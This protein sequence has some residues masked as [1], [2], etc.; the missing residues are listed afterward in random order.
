MYINRESLGG[1]LAERLPIPSLQNVTAVVDGKFPVI[2]GYVW[3]WSCRQDGE[4]SS[5]VL[6]GWEFCICCAASTGKAPRDDSHMNFSSM[7]GV[8]PYCDCLTATIKAAIGLPISEW[9][10]AGRHA[11]HYRLKCSSRTGSAALTVGSLT[12]SCR[13]RRCH[14]DTHDGIATVVS[15]MSLSHRYISKPEN[16][17]DAP[18]VLNRDRR[19]FRSHHNVAPRLFCSSCLSFARALA[20][21]AFTVPWGIPKRCAV[22]RMLRPSTSRN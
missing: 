5:K 15:D 3:R 18:P 16:T 4:I 8:L 11:L 14:A 22:S 13:C 7:I 6:T 21:R 17:V 1:Q 20:T 19:A 10:K 2:E 9:P 12:S